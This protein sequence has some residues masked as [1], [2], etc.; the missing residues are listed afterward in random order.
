VSLDRH[1]ARRKLFKY[2]R[3]LGFTDDE[4]HDLTAVFLS[5]DT[6]SWKDLTDEQ[7]TRLLDAFEGFLLIQQTIIL[8]AP[9]GDD[10]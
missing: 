1:A 2:A 7:M 4:R 10:P 9:I 8:R 3:D 5:T 6:T